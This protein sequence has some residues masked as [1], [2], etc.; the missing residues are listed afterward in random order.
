MSEFKTSQSFINACAVY[1]GDGC[2]D[3]LKQF[4]SVYPNLNLS[5]ISINGLVPLTPG[6]GDTIGVESDDSTYMEEQVHKDEGV[7]I[8]Q[9]ILNGAVSPSVLFVEDLSTQGA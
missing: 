8:A 3:C 2:D 4:G 7:V 6:G 1:Y 5:K 9:P